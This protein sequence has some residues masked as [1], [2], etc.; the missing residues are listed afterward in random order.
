MGLL[1]RGR[2]GCLTLAGIFLGVLLLWETWAVYPLKV[3]VVFLHEISH[4]L[5][6]VLTGGSILEIEVNAEQGGFC[7]TSGGIRFL[8]LSAGYLG[9]MLFG[10]VILVTAAH[11]TRD[12]LLCSALGVFLIAITLLYVRNGFGFAFGLLFGVALIG[13]SRLGSAGAADLSLRTVGLT[14][15]LYAV[16]D[17]KS[18]I[19]DR[20]GIGS[21]ADMLAQSTGIPT[22]VWG[23][24]WILAAL[25]VTG[26]ALIVSL[27]ARE[28][29]GS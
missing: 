13:L 6:A 4:G 23:V 16:L 28:R 3:L 9:S 14:S 29:P 18:D 10:A 1:T 2:G 7:R 12:R 8:T 20:P 26:F 27:R 25:V 11:S 5:A 17:I 21:D 19:L 15:C 22:L 24:V